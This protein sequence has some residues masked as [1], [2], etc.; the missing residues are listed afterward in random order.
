MVKKFI[1]SDFER[2]KGGEVVELIVLMTPWTLTGCQVTN[3]EKI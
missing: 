3:R 2:V 1:K